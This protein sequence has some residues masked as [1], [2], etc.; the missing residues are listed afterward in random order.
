MRKILYTA[1]ASSAALALAACG[2]SEDASVEAEAESVEEIAEEAVEPVEE[3][4][5]AD[6]AADTNVS[7]ASTDT[8]AVVAQEADDAGD[9][10]EATARDVAAERQRAGENAA[11]KEGNRLIDKG[12]DAAKKELGN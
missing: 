10:A 11:K 8:S 12:V 2:T 9:A 1:F 3:A 6:A 7:E 4:P 5:V